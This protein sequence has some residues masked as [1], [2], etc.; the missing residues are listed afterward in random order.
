MLPAIWNAG[1]VMPRRSSSPCPRAANAMRTSVATRH[2]RRAVRIRAC[3]PSRAV[4]ARNDGTSAIG[5]TITNSEEKA[6]RRYSR[7]VTEGSPMRGRE[8][9]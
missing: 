8:R 3:G 1:I 5:S 2:A 6:R 7:S 9:G 4:I